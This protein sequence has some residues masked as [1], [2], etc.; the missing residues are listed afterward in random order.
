MSPPSSV[1]KNQTKQK[2]RVTQI[3]SR[4]YCSVL[5]LKM[6]V[7]CSSE[8]SVTFYGLGTELYT[9]HKVIIVLNSCSVKIQDFTSIST[10]LNGTDGLLNRIGI[11]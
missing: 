1:S 4:D 6:D 10:P 3:E 9:Q 5:T 7:I 11:T 8:T 2:I